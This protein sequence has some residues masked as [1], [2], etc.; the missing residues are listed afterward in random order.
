MD[1][2]VKTGFQPY[3]IVFGCAEGDPVILLV[4]GTACQQIEDGWFISLQ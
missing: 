1:G 2:V 4:S 3:F